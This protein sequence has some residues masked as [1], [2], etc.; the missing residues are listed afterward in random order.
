LGTTAAWAQVVVNNASTAGE[1]YARGVGGVIQAQGQKNL[2]DSQ[3]AINLTDARANQINNQVN[4]VNAFWQKRAVYEQHLQEKNYETQQSRARKLE[5]IGLENLTSEQFDRTTGQVTWLKVLTQSQYDENRKTLE[6]LFQKRA[7]NGYLSSDDYLLAQ[8]TNKAFR[9]QINAQRDD[10]PRPIL[11][12][13][14]RF[15]VQLNREMNDNLS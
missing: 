5:R 4:S 14:N 12:Q 8:T 15:L 13:M 11:E 1:S 6:A 7:E 2:S 10:Y 9:D 3:A